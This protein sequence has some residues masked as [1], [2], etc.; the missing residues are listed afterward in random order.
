M[1]KR[2]EQH[3]DLTNEVETAEESQLNKEI[4][5]P[6]LLMFGLPTIFALVVMGTFGIVD[7]VFAMRRLGAESMAAISVVVPFSIITIG[8][9][10][11]FAI[12]GSALVAKKN[13]MNL[14]HE[15]RQIFTLL[16]IVSLIISTVIALFTIIFPEVLLNLLGA[17]DEIMELAKTYLRLIAISTPLVTIAQV[18]NQFL[19]ADGKPMLGMGVSLFGSL[20]SAGLNALFL[21]HFDWGIE[22]LGW[23]TII[24]YGVTALIGFLCFVRNKTGTLYFVRPKWDMGAI[25]QS[26]FNGVGA[27]ISTAA[28]AV[29]T[30][31]MNN[32]LVRMDGVGAIGVAVAG[33]VM[34][35][36]AALANVFMGYISGTTPLIS[37][38]YGKGNHARQKKLFKYNIKILA[39]IAVVTVLGTL[40]FSDLIMR[41]YV[42]AG[43]ELHTMAVRGL[44]IASFSFICLGFNIFAAGHFAALNNGFIGGLLSTLRTVVFNL[45]L[46][47]T[48]PHIWDLTGVWSATPI[49][50]ALAIL[51]SIFCLVKMDKKYHYLG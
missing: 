1:N 3:E 26:L 18:F 13:G 16:C 8:I 10:I 31:V 17:N 50:E 36:H 34:G 5:L 11:T 14:K 15:A 2:N 39:V 27:F 4:T 48:L 24:G 43:T 20:L 47:L 35:V 33:M 46:L 23:A 38:N 42:P 45:G 6:L 32:V 9:G 28:A 21:F 25:G 22:G 41:V 51:V 37:Y 44:R 40:A 29:V 19:I 30:I 49:A 12:G 7:G